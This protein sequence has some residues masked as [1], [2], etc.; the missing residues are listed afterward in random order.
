MNNSG[1]CSS[2]IQPYSS[3]SSKGFNVKTGVWHKNVSL[4]PWLLFRRVT[5]FL[6]RLLTNLSKVLLNHLSQ[7][8]QSFLNSRK[9]QIINKQAKSFWVI[10]LKS[11]FKSW[12]QV[13]SFINCSLKFVTRVMWLESPTSE[14]NNCI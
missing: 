5:P 3:K 13:K 4:L 8:K 14:R 1:E 11:N 12:M 10:C 9:M 6:L 2:I 7:T